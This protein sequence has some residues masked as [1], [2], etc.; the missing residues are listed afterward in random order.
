MT[1]LEHVVLWK[2]KPKGRLDKEIPRDASIVR[3]NEVSE[4]IIVRE[5][6]G[7]ARWII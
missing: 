2:H 7:K 1:S 4:I 5:I 6:L 3:L